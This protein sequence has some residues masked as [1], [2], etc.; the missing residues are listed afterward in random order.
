MMDLSHISQ[1]SPLFTSMNQWLGWT[2]QQTSTVLMVSASLLVLAAIVIGQRRN[3]KLNQRVERLQRDLLVANNSAI[4]M[5]QQLLALEKK[6]ISQH[7]AS[8]NIHSHA[9]QLAQ[10]SAAIAEKALSENTSNLKHRLN[11][12]VEEEDETPAYELAKQWL[13]QG[14]DIQQV[15]KKTGLSHAEVSLIKAL[16]KQQKPSPPSSSFNASS[17]VNSQHT[18]KTAKANNVHHL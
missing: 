2:S 8:H 1:L 16:Q 18:R 10:K 12:Q 13:S 14:A 7:Q 5:G 6:M 11:G 4:G 17:V 15:I 3:R 9:D